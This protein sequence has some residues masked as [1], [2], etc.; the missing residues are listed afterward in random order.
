MILWQT[1]DSTNSLPRGINLLPIAAQSGWD[2]NFVGAIT[3]N[4]ESTSPRGTLQSTQPVY[5][6]GVSTIPRIC[7][8]IL[9]SGKSWYNIKVY[10]LSIKSNVFDMISRQACLH[11]KY[12]LKNNVFKIF[13][14][15]TT[16][17]QKHIRSFFFLFLFFNPWSCSLTSLQLTSADIKQKLY[18]H[19]YI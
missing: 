2:K 8:A 1:E 6:R 5:T 18:S 17:T 14:D 16:G 7:I 13:A 4:A 19:I 10:L 11:L 9:L 3:K 12:S 15:V